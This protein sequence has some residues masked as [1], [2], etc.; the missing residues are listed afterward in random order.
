MYDRVFVADHS[1]FSHF[2]VCKIKI[3]PV[4]TFWFTNLKFVNLKQVQIDY[5]RV[6]IQK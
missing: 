3:A 6:D 4:H 2:I 1:L 5:S